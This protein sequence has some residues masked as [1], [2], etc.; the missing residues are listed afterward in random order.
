MKLSKSKLKEIIREE[1]LNEYGE[2]LPKLNATAYSFLRKEAAYLVGDSKDVINAIKK[3]DDL[4][5]RN[6]INSLYG[7]LIRLDHVAKGKEKRYVQ[8]SVKE[9]KLN[10]DDFASKALDLLYDARE[11]FDTEISKVTKILKQ[12]DKIAKTANLPAFNTI[13]KKYIDGFYKVANKIARNV[14]DY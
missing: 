4:E 5:T 8:E 12:Q 13:Y 1:L 10:E 3:Q 2:K 14:K 9:Q 6:A 11:D 7:S